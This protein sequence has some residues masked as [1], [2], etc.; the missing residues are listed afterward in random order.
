MNINVQAEVNDDQTA[1]YI[2]GQAMFKAH[3]DADQKRPLCV[4]CVFSDESPECDGLCCSK[5]KRKDGM[6]ITWRPIQ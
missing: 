6:S 1:I 3:Y 2:N 4:G 5:G